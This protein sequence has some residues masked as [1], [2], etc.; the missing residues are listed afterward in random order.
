MALPADAGSK[1]RGEHELSPLFGSDSNSSRFAPFYDFYDAAA[2]R[3]CLSE[4]PDHAGRTIS[5]RGVVDVRTREI[6]QVLSRE[7]GVN[8]IV[9]NRP[10]GLGGIGAAHVAKAKPDGYTL[11]VGSI[12][13]P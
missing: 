13:E 8:V 5:R 10:G 3:R 4:S 2:R 7:L 12:N 1:K 11:L 9:D 6:G